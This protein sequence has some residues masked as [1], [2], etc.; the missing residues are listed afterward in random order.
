MVDYSITLPHSGEASYLHR[1]LKHVEFFDYPL[2]DMAELKKTYEEMAVK[3]HKGLSFHAPMP[4][5]VYFPFSGV[6][7]FFLNE[8]PERRDLSLQLIEDTLQHAR[9]W[10][11]DY[12][13][14]HLTYG[15]TDTT[16]PIKAK[17][18]ARDTCERFAALSSEYQVPINIEFAAYTQAFNEPEQFI[19]LV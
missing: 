18:L 12:V 5:P 14:T 15:K 7:C 19:E 4:R 2:N 16:D 8:E 9:D 6:T 11:A 3:G 10:G 17:Q 1:G 13:V